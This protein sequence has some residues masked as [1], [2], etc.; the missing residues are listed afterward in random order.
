MNELEFDKKT[1]LM[2]VLQ[3]MQMHLNI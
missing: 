1:V 2:L 3:N